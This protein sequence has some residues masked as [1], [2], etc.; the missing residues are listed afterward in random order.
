MVVVHTVDAFSANNEGGNPAG[1]VVD[2]DSLNATQM[3]SIAAA[4]GLSETA[5]IQ[6]HPQ[7]DR[8]I[9]FFTP[10]AEVG[11][12]G[13]ATIAS[14]HLLMEQGWVEPG[15]YQMWTQ[16]G[17]QQIRCENNGRV[18]M[19]QNRPTFGPVLSPG[20]V[21][22]SLGISEMQLM[23]AKALPVQ[24]ASTGLHKIFAPIRDL[25]SLM[26]IEP[27]LDAIEA[28]SRSV[29]AIGIY[30]FTLESLNGGIAQCRNFAPVVGIQEDSA[31]GTSAAATACL[32]F[33]HGA[34]NAT[35]AG[36]L[37][38]EQGYALHQ[39]SEIQVRLS[40]EGRNIQE[41]WVAGRGTTRTRREI[42]A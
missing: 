23:D 16:S 27:D 11:L 25:E 8:A 33:H 40:V 37:I 9:R 29:D 19:S 20:P 31:T 35:E 32:L 2:A 6:H 7:A 14:W 34:V 10:N 28:I 15:H 41:V 1:V 36:D 4:M 24:V 12:C 18:A 21:A 39:P 13:H 3:Q 38:F 42:Q 17:M 5:F 26:S 22:A 30:C